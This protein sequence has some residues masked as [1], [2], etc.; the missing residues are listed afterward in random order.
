MGSIFAQSSG[1]GKAGVAVWRISGS[2]AL[3]A[4]IILSQKKSFEPRKATLCD[5]RHP[6]NGNLIDKGMAIYFP[7]PKSFTGED[8]VELY[9]HGSIAVSK[10]I[11][12]ALN[13]LDFLRIA[14]PGEFS[15]RSFL[16]GKMDLVQAEA[17]VDLIN[18]ETAMQH[19]SAIRQMSGEL[20]SLYNNWRAQLLS[21]LAKIQALIDFPDEDI[22][23]EILLE[24]E[25]LIKNL[26]LSISKHLADQGR[27]EK[28]RQ[29][30]KLA[31]FGPPNVGKSSLMNYLANRDISIV[32]DI[33]GTTRDFIETFIDIAGYPISL[34]DTAGIREN[35][36]DI[37]EQEG[38]KRAKYQVQQADI[39]ILLLDVAHNLSDLDLVLS[40]LIT[41]DTIVIR[42][43]I[44]LLDDDAK[45]DTHLIPI[46]IIQRLNLD[47]L[48]QAIKQQAEKIAGPGENASLSRARYRQNLSRALE[49]LQ[50]LDLQKDLVL[51]AE[52]LRQAANCVSSIV[53]KIE[54][55]EILGEIFASFCIGK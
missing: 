20:S 16:N 2:Q 21:S 31:I 29:G 53:G 3:K 12:D 40:E 55:E 6:K 18:A 10:I 36:H 49:Y 51:A 39:K 22:P 7:A 9:L 19:Q 42:N 44:D 23:P 50:I 34:V 13:S 27:G 14:Q 15:K 24:L 52:H 25:L 54:V 1:Y 33:A 43:K 32:S 47:R 28:I 37:I 48:E 46:S 8:V 41:A 11:L 30:I 45:N 17:V 26:A 5:L 4:L 38:I 35:T